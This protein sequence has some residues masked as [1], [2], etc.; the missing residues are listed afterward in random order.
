MPDIL[1]TPTAAEDLRK[2]S[3][4]NRRRVL[5][6]LQRIQNA[7]SR[8]EPIRVHSEILNTPLF[9]IRFASLRLLYEINKGRL[10]V[11]S[12]HHR[13]RKNGPNVRNHL[14]LSERS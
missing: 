4:T 12:I 2:L 10:I 6:S 8:P 5:K 13:A 14:S 9:M 3:L 11:L 7:T 1:L